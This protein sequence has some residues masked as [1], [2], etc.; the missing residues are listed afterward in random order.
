M[1]AQNDEQIEQP[2]TW[3]LLNCKVDNLTVTS[4]T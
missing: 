3:N 4:S 2:T 1:I